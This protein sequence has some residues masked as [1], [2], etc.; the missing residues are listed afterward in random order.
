MLVSLLTPTFV[1]GM[2]QPFSIKILTQ[3]SSYSFKSY[4]DDSGINYSAST[5]KVFQ[6]M[7][8]WSTAWPAE[9]LKEANQRAL[10][11]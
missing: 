2:M 7:S 3:L 11:Q 8:H 1:R 5:L 4:A 10:Q 6:I 9:G